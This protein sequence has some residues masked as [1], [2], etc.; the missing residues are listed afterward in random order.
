MRLWKLALDVPYV[1]GHEPPSSTGL[2]WVAVLVVLAI[3][4]TVLLVRRGR[5]K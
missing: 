4:L 2:L 3:V 1:P 5:R